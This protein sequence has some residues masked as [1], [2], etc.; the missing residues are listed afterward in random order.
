MSP[1]TRPTAP[2]GPQEN[3]GYRFALLFWAVVAA[4]VKEYGARADPPLPLADLAAYLKRV[5]R[6]VVELLQRLQAGTMPPLRQRAR[7]ER[8]APPPERRAPRFRL[9]SRYG[10]LASEIGWAGRGVAKQIAFM[11]NQPDTAALIA[12][13]PQA[14]RILRPLCHTLGLTVT[15]VPPLPKRVRAKRVADARAVRTKPRAPRLTRKE[16]EAV[17]W[18][19]KLGGRPAAVL[20]KKLPRG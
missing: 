7:V 19:P 3:L 11:L 1:A 13:S 8:D 4:L 10:W 14:Q 5:H 16:R 6:R 9:P 18:H 20:A 15:A 2:A 12:A 17:L